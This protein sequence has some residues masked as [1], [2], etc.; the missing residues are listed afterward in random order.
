MHTTS[1]FCGVEKMSFNRR[2]IRT[3][4]FSNTRNLH[5]NDLHG[6]TTVNSGVRFPNHYTSLH[7]SRAKL[8]KVLPI[9]PRVIYRLTSFF[10][11]MLKVALPL[12]GA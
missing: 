7:S 9:K 3:F 10:L 1:V 8:E 4:C 2:Q 5:P 6:N 11:S 12:M